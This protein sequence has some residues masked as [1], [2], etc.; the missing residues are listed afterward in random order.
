MSKMRAKM[1]I[2]NIQKFGEQEQLKLSAVARSDGY[3][4]TGGSDEDNTFARYTPS[5]QL[6]ITIANPDLVGTFA[7]GETFYVDFTPV[8]DAPKTAE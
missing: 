5:A 4:A 3:S 7:E 1:T 6:T 2:L 8:P